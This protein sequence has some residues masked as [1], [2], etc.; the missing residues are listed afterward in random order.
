[1]KHFWSI[2]LFLGASIGL[3]QAENTRYDIAGKVVSNTDSSPLEMTTIRLF[4]YT[5]ADSILVQG[6]QTDYDG[7]YTLRGIAA[8]QYKLF[9]SNIGYKEQVQTV[10]V[11]AKNTQDNQM[12]LKTIRLKE[13]VTAL[14]EVEVQGHAAEMTVKGDTIEYNTSAYQVGENEGGNGNGQNEN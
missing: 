11:S 3:A 6:A 2:L 14:A 13:D 5:G 4:R 8:G 12:T 1:M 10:Q 9:V 7:L